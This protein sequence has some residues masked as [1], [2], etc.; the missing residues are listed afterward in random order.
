MHSRTVL[1]TSALLTFPTFG[2]SP[3]AFFGLFT[4]FTGSEAGFLHQA[5]TTHGVLFT[6]YESPARPEAMSDP[7][8][9]GGDRARFGCARLLWCPSHRNKASQEAEPAAHGDGTR[10]PEDRSKGGIPLEGVW[11]RVKALEGPPCGN[12]VSAAEPRRR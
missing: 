3:I 12:S 10:L 7:S 6:S 8:S 1:G 11:L 9:W 4:P 5:I 2:P